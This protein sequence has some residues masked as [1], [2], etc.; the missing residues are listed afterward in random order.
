M[1]IKNLEKA[2]NINSIQLHANDQDSVA[3]WLKEWQMKENNHVLHYKLQG[4]SDTF[5]K[6]KDADFSIIMQTEHQKKFLQ[7][8]GKNG[9]CIDSTHG[10]NAYDF[11][12]TTILVIDEFGEGQP[13]GWCISN[14]D[15]FRF[16]KL[17]FIKLKEHSGNFCPIWIMSDMASQYYEAF[18]DA[19]LCEPLKFWCT[20]HVDKAWREELHKKIHN[21]EM[22]ADIYK[23][24]RF[25]LQLSDRN[26]FDDYLHLL[27]NYLHSSD[28]TQ[29]FAEYFEKYWVSN[30]QNWA[31]CYRM[32]LGI[33][34]NM[35]VESFHKVFKYSYL[36]GKHNKRID[37]CLFALL[38]FNRDKV[39][40]R[41]I[42]LTKGKI[43]FK[44]KMVHSRHIA[45]LQLNESFTLDD[46]EARLVQSETN[47][48]QYRVLKHQE[49][50]EIN[51]CFT[52][53]PECKV[54]AHLY[55]CDCM[56]FLTKNILCKHIHLIHRLSRVCVTKKNEPIHLPTH[57]IEL[58]C[59]VIKGCEPADINIL[60]NNIIKNLNNLVNL[61]TCSTVSDEEGLKSL[62]KNISLAQNTFLNLT[63]NKQNEL[64]FKS[65]V[66]SNTRITKQ[67]PFY[68]TKKKRKTSNI[69]LA[70]PSADEID[71]SQ[72]QSSSKLNKPKLE[73]QTNC[74]IKKN[75]LSPDQKKILEF[76][77]YRKS[78]T[79]HMLTENE[80]NI[81]TAHLSPEIINH[82]ITIIQSLIYPEVFV[83]V[84][85]KMVCISV[86][87][88]DLD[89]H[90]ICSKCDSRKLSKQ[91][92]Q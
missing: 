68:S 81:D 56:D 43:S 20:W 27:M 35:Y 22:E 92:L 14:S 23:R 72:L 21:L 17:F 64:H 54:C 7:Q 34:T 24:I 13:V 3:I 60:K 91:E 5:N 8:F 6:F 51:E 44:L 1:D 19:Y 67:S 90:W 32:G 63:T 36:Q 66:P 48:C 65:N 11:L 73:T 76:F 37:N 50:C 47:A 71:N 31:F 84:K 41:I 83:K 59:K 87:E 30:K 26:L 18:C 16:L 82:D 74:V 29:L 88:M 80:L 52:K 42:K 4:E 77:G 45:S 25:L 61:V 38:K 57:S 86:S 85:K 49:L 40:E 55:S 69:R 58:E 12:L 46:K 10:T 70:K 79:N 62:H 9:V 33:N 75:I 15:S 78:H 28:L 2:F 53:C 39:Y 89:C